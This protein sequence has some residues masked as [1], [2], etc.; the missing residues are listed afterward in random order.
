MLNRFGQLTLHQQRQLYEQTIT[1]LGF[2]VPGIVRTGEPLQAELRC[3]VYGSTFAFPN[4]LEES[5]L[6]DDHVIADYDEEHRDE[7]F[8]ISSVMK[9]P[10][11]GG[12]DGEWHCDIILR[13]DDLSPGE[14]RLRYVITFGLSD[15]RELIPNS[16][17][18]VIVEADF[19]VVEP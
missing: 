5:V 6:V 14:H 4:V 3:W 17:K 1:V 7:T 15:E 10:P 9:P 19:R 16:P 13:A 11:K 2:D 8:W 18:K 12:A